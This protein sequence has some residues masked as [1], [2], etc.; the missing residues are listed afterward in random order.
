MPR[1]TA[2]HRQANRAQIVAA[3]RRCFSG[4]GF[5]QTSMPDIAAEAGLSVGAPYRYFAGKEEII[6]EIAGDAFRMMFAPV[7]QLTDA[8]GITVADLVAAAVDPMSGNLAVDGAGRSVPVDELLR[9][10]V[11]AWGELLRN[12]GL[13]QVATTGFEHVRER[14]ADALR[15][16]QQAGTVPV[17]LDPDRGARVVMALLHGF[18]LQHAAFGLVDTAGFA[19]DVR[20]LLN[21]LPPR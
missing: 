13:R 5:H 6:L 8:T 17:E 16:G 21:D 12:A 10:A 20:V 7:E 11:Q 9:C 2:E 14:V 1:I 19:D 18:V 4:D 15:N 3:A